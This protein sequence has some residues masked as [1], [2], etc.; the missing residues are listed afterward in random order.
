MNWVV[1]IWSVTAGICF[2]LG[3][4]HLALW[5]RSR[6]S[7]A[8][9]SFAIGA[10]AAGGYA[11]HDLFQITA[12]TPAQY[13]ELARWTLVLGTVVALALV[14]FTRLYLQAGRLWLLWLIVSLRALMLGLNFAFEPNFYVAEVTE[15]R[16][17][18]LLGETIVRPVGEPRGWAFLQQLSHLLIIVFA[19]DAA[20]T[21]ANRGRGRAAWLIG[22][23]IAGSVALAML[24]TVLRAWG[25]LPTAF[26][27]QLMLL[28]VAV[29]AYQ[30]SLDMFHAGRLADS[31]RDTE[32]RV[33]L[34]AQAAELGFWD[35]DL[36][37]DEV[38]IDDTERERTGI[39]GPGLA[40]H[41]HY[42][43]LIHRDDRERVREA[44]DQAVERGDDFDA[45]FR[46]VDSAGRERWI[47][48][49]GQ[50]ERG[51]QGEPLRLRGISMDVTARKRSEIDLQK[52][53]SA[54][55]HTQ[56]VFAMGQLSA[57]LAHELNQPL[58]AILRN[59]EAGELFLQHDPPDLDELR[60]IFV[61]IQ[62][63]DQRAAEVID[64]MRALL[65]H[66]ELR[67]EAIGLE[68]LIGQVADLLNSEMQ[69][70]HVSLHTAFPPGL[71]EVRG[72]CVHLQQ[73]LVN[74]LLNGLD[75][76]DA[77]R[78]EVR[79]IEISAVDRE[80]G[81]VELAVADSGTG[82]DAD[83]SLN[84]FEPFVT[85]K[86]EGTGIG[87]AISKTIVEAHGGHIWA[88]NKSGGGACIR[89]TLPVART[90]EAA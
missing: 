4:I 3:A 20:R 74:L 58:G 7:L 76:I 57:A 43:S 9:L 68:G 56:R 84:M 47:A 37:R 38:W 25:I 34:A 87:L 79:R 29:L 65:R 66:R 22:V 40:S 75:A 18:S 1:Y 46:L 6:K 32:A 53:R 70:R 2:T 33:R 41:G 62:Q 27:G 71:P 48:A 83:L 16:P 50:V 13:A 36:K 19:L 64:R 88:E 82:I 30:L 69:A 44:L 14:A 35:W 86:S 26:V 8:N 78:N 17:L 81:W 61:D 59:A 55:S 45:E 54:L 80:D 31:L 90:G 23:A 73:V 51:A 24:F 89:F 15:L 12:A 63:D 11:T 42:L 77:G 67:F 39:S 10:L 28:P 5:A 21:A 49:S 85:Q 52:H 72:E 60:E